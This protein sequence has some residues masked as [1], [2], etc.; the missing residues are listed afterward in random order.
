[1]SSGMNPLLKQALTG[2]QIT[3]NGDVYTSGYFEDSAD[4]GPGKKGSTKDIERIS[5]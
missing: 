4:F 1:M 3:H 5:C 2:R